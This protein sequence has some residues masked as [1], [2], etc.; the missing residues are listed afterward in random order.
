[1]SHHVT[2]FVLYCL[3]LFHRK[4]VDGTPYGQ[5][6]LFFHHTTRIVTVLH[7]VDPAECTAGKLLFVESTK[8]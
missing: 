5:N 7:I 8:T 6:S 4:I 1:M 2:N 3:K